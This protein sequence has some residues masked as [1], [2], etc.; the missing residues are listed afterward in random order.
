VK[1]TLKTKTVADSEDESVET[2]IKT[3]RENRNDVLYK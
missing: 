3:K 1:Y 2:A